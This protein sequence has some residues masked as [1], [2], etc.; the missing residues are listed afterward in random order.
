VIRSVAIVASSPVQILRPRERTREHIVA[1]QEDGRQE[2][3]RLGFRAE[4]IDLRG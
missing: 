1:A 3:S 4:D 2:C